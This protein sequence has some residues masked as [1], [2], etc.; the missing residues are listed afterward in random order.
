MEPLWA[1]GIP[2]CCRS[3]AFW[4]PT[5]AALVVWAVYV[6]L[7]RGRNA[8]WTS[9][10]GAL[11]GALTVGSVCVAAKRFDT[12]AANVVFWS[13][14][15]GTLAASFAAIRAKLNVWPCWIVLAG[16]GLA[17]LYRAQAES[18]SGCATRCVATTASLGLHGYGLILGGVALWLMLPRKTECRQSAGVALGAIAL[19][20]LGA[21][22]PWFGPLATQVV[23]WLLA[24]LTVAAAACAI[25]ARSPVYSAIWFALSL[26]GTAGL[27]LAQHA[28]FLAVATIVVYAGAIVV[29]FLFV[30]MLAQPDGHATY[31]RITWGPLPK[32]VSVAAAAGLLAVLTLAVARIDAAAVVPAVADADSAVRH[33]D[34]T[35]R[36][37]AELFSRHLVSVEIAGTLLLVALVGAVAIV[38][39][40]KERRTA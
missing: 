39:Q 17:G 34:H 10:V 40:G 18:F 37:G 20:L 33:P 9:H 26:L 31:D 6:G 4:G 23:F 8:R 13:L 14:A 11:A 28:Q 5:L 15:A 32:L 19:G 21:A 12:L 35:A 24:A 2:A 7:T 1:V 29:T 25:T 30:I 36:L 3:L 27:F 38:V 16:L 22:Q